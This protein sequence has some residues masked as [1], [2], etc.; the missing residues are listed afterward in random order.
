MTSFNFKMLSYVTD[1]KCYKHVVIQQNE[2]AYK[3]IVLIKEKLYL[4]YKQNIF[5][6]SLQY[7]ILDTKTTPMENLYFD[8]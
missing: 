4:F 8:Q 1:L 7:E 2:M 6:M 3:C 5:E